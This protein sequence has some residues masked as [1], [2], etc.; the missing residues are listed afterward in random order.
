MAAAPAI[1]G[2][3]MMMAA[4]AFAQGLPVA[5][6]NDADISTEYS[7]TF[8]PK[9]PLDSDA[10]LMAGG[11]AGGL[12]LA[13]AVAAY[14]RR[15]K[16]APPYM[17]AGGALALAVLNPVTVERKLENIPNDIVVVIDKT[18][19]N[20]VGGR[21]ALVETIRAHVESQIGAFEN[22]H[23]RFVEMEEAVGGMA[24]P[25][26]RLFE[27]LRE[28]EGL[29]PDYLSG[30]VLITDGQIHDTPEASPLG[31]D[32]P[33]HTLLSGAAGEYDRA[34]EL[35]G[36]SSFGMVHEDQIVRFRVN[37]LGA[38]GA[39]GAVDVNVMTDGK[40]L[41]T[42]SVAPGAIAETKVP[43]NAVGEN[44]YV[45]EAAPLAGEL[46]D[47][48]NRIVVNINGIRENLNVLMIS[49][50]VNNS[51]RSLRS[52]YKADPDSNLIHLMAL[53]LPLQLDNTPKEELSLTPVPLTEIFGAA[54]E[55]YDV[56]VFNN[57]ED[58]RAI[59][60]RYLRSIKERIEAGVPSLV[61]AGPEFAGSKSLSKTPIGDILPVV[62]NGKTT[63][64]L[65]VPQLTAD[66]YRHPITKSLSGAGTPEEEEPS[67]GSWIRV[68]GADVEK[69]RVLMETPS[70]QPLLVTH[71]NGESR[72]AV[73]LSDSF[74]LWDEGFEGGGPQAELIGR[75]SHWLM[76]TR[77]LEEEALRVFKTGDN[78]IVIER[79][80][81]AADAPEA[82]E[83]QV[84][85]GGE[86][87]I[88]FTT[89]ISPGVWQAIYPYTHDG[90]YRVTNENG[91]ADLTAYIYAGA[92][93]GREMDNVVASDAP[94]RPVTQDT[95][96]A[97]F[98]TVA[99]DGSLQMP[100]LR[101]MAANRTDKGLAGADWAGFV[102]KDIQELQGIEKSPLIP[103]WASALMVA[104]ALIWGWSRESDHQKIKNLGAGL[105]A[106]R[107]RKSAVDGAQDQTDPSTPAL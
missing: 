99:A 60:T 25:G 91:D 75:I 42:L 19:S 10:G 13:F 7:I 48:N 68:M 11:I 63:E 28:T 86:T 52:L 5:P 107:G 43:V 58:L 21:A 69:G 22:T 84:P 44:V 72:V 36:A 37:D 79:Q 40:I 59:P 66:G 87:R 67:W 26:S 82:A 85:G 65:F 88:E 80:T 53:R 83:I 24:N 6:N 27:T 61:T 51:V 15:V 105:S 89:Q 54:L 95:Q 100:D 106:R 71:E 46:T 90:I 74:P 12:A 8:E 4:P 33:F 93:Y 55:K 32:V 18:A 49:G 64:E 77:D 81:M 92:E 96:G 47:E 62:P 17:L 73:L 102:Q 50:S 103:G 38:A 45:I 14:R 57:Y 41:R 2:A 104:S 101:Q 39:A 23:I 98:Y 35:V 3:H 29:N 20:K 56:I 70:G 9:A 94:L 78:Q 30:V 31:P 97:V 34:V 1:F 76:R 16:V